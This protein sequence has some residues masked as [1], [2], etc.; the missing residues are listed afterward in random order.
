MKPSSHQEKGPCCLTGLIKHDRVIIKYAGMHNSAHKRLQRRR[1]W[2]TSRYYTYLA[3]RRSKAEGR[4]FTAQVTTGTV[5]HD[6]FFLY[7][8]HVSMGSQALVRISST[9]FVSEMTMMVIS[10]T[11]ADGNEDCLREDRCPCSRIIVVYLV[12]ALRYLICFTVMLHQPCM[13]NV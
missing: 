3:M 4:P 6:Y 12:L 11:V 10:C 9:C 7:Y 1:C 13:R 5:V 8:Y 2:P